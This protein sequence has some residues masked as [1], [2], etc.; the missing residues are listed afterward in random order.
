MERIGS[1]YRGI[2]GVNTAIILL[3]AFGVLPPKISALL[4]NTYTV[5]LG[6][7]STTDL[8]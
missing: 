8:L 1:N 3:G 7:K 6:L 4:H 5:G 2:V